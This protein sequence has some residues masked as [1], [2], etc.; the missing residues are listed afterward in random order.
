MNSAR[1]SK[2]NEEKS[3]TKENTEPK[4]IIEPKENEK[5]NGIQIYILFPINR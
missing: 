4:E 5:N 1:E 2:L 3:E